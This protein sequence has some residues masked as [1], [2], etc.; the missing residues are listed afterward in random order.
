[1]RW[2]VSA[3]R[4]QLH[5]FPRGVPGRLSSRRSPPRPR[6]NT[7]STRP[8][9]HSDSK[10][11]SGHSDGKMITN[12]CSGSRRGRGCQ[13]NTSTCWTSQHAPRQIQ[14]RALLR[15]L[16]CERGRLTQS[17]PRN[18]WPNLMRMTLY[19]TVFMS[20]SS[21]KGPLSSWAISCHSLRTQSLYSSQPDLSY[22]SIVGKWIAGSCT[23]THYSNAPIE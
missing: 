14:R 3:P 23:H 20:S 2:R 19:V 17:W 16:R 5:P 21:Q 1:M 9:H 6:S 15:G 22:V 18:S 7:A 11:E 4:P 8:G 12:R 13:A 10:R